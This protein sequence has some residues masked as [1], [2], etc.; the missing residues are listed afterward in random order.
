MKKLLFTFLA[1]VSLFA[2]APVGLLAQGQRPL[3][4]SFGP[5]APGSYTIK[6]INPNLPKTPEYQTNTGEQK[7]YTLGTWLEI[8]VEFASAVPVTPELQFKYYVVI[9]NQ[10]LVGT[11][12]HVHVPAGQSLFSVMYVA[13][14]TLTTLLKGQAIT[15]ATLQN[16]DVQ[17]LKPGV[18][19]PLAEKMLKPGPAFYNT[20]QQ[21]N[22]LVLNKAETPFAPLYWDRY[23][24]IKASNGQ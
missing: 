13:P 21:V 2:L 20:M 22:G 6:A 4:G 10:L 17:I 5:L 24:A 14:R 15:A 16:V 1:A 9:G 7:R 11:V 23:E 18:A 12:T 3:P 8:E 19:A